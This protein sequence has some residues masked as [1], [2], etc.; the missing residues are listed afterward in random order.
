MSHRPI[1]KKIASAGFAIALAWPASVL[2]AQTTTPS[3]ATQTASPSAT[4]ASL[5]QAPTDLTVFLTAEE[6]A[7]AFREKQYQLVIRQIVRIQ[8]NA[9]AAANY[10]PF[11]LWILRAE[12]QLHLKN[13][14]D[15]N[16]AYKQALKVAPDEDSKSVAKA[17]LV[18]LAKQT[19]LAYQP[20]TAEAPSAKPS[21][22]APT[23]RPKPIDII[24]IGQ[25]PVAFSALYRDEL[26]ANLPTLKQA[27]ASESLM[28]IAAAAKMLDDLAVL[29]IAASAK[30][31]EVDKMALRLAERARD[32]MT[33]DLKKNTEE[34]AVI[35]GKANVVDKI[36]VPIFNLN[37][38]MVGSEDRYRKH[39]LERNDAATLQTIIKNVTK[40]EDASKEL[41][42]RLH[43]DA[44]SFSGVVTQS[45]QLGKQA[46]DILTTDY[47][48]EDPQLRQLNNPTP[49]VTIKKN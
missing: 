32:L 5:I 13:V 14:Y 38:Q 23:E 4:A 7:Q 48:G 22:S 31:E 40:Y 26:A 17:T 33:Q 44:T 43:Q 6:L 45:Q 46:L 34:V 27:A 2:R 24:D 8:Q 49:N 20:K 3:A 39:G 9:K 15:A 41:A 21:S 12:A 42:E 29:E 25:R 1:L 35:K 37:G 47:S 28:T 10:S 11:D 19:G 18:L 30:S 16:E 36:A